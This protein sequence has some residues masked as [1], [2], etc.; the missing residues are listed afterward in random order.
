MRIVYINQ[1]FHRL[2]KA[3]L[4]APNYWFDSCLKVDRYIRNYSLQGKT[5]SLSFM[6]GNCHKAADPDGN[7]SLFLE[8]QGDL[9]DHSEK[10]K[11]N[12]KHCPYIYF[13]MQTDP[14]R[15]FPHYN[16]K[17]YPIYLCKHSCGHYGIGQGQHRLCISGTLGIPL[18]RV[19]LGFSNKVCDSC[20]NPRSVARL[21][22]F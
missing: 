16:S 19:R 14:D 18:P 8:D 22:S 20:E 5:L 1:N 4:V 17:K 12:P 7:C 6:Y 13:L 15:M 3:I 10:D 21:Y 2:K 9:S 11:D